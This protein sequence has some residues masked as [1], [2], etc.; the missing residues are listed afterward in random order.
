MTR[1]GCHWCFFPK[2]VAQ[3]LIFVGLADRVGRVGPGAC[4]PA[5]PLVEGVVP[6]V[7][8]LEACQMPLADGCTGVGMVA[9]GEHLGDRQLR[10]LKIE[11]DRPGVSPLASPRSTAMSTGR[12]RR[13]T[14]ATGRVGGGHFG[15]LFRRPAGAAT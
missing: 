9:D 3:R 11:I 13:P 8:L 5:E 6:R 15:R 1:P 7:V 2:G 4:R 10:A 12:K 14:L